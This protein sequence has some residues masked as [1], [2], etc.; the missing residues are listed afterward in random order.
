MIK[1]N[2]NYC[3][4]IVILLILISGSNYYPQNDHR[5]NNLKIDT[6]V[7]GISTHIFTQ[8]NLEDAKAA[9]SLML[10]EIIHNYWKRPDIFT[11]PA[12]YDNIDKIKSDIEANK[13]EMVALTSSEYFIL[14]DQVKIT[15][16]LT[17]KWGAI[18]QDRLLLL[19]REDSGIKTI[20]D[21][22]K[23]KVSIFSYVSDEFSL[24]TIWYKT[25]VLSNDENYKKDYGPFLEI[26]L[27][28]ARAIM[29]V[30]FKKTQAVIVSEKEFHIANELNP[31]LGKQLKIIANSKPILYSALCYTEKLK[32]HKNIFI[33]ELVDSFCNVHKKSIGKNFLQIFR[34]TQFIPYKDEYMNN[35]EELYNEFIEVSRKKKK[36]LE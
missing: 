30:F 8:A 36:Y 21:L 1:S 16:F 19:V 24:P 23:K 11:S 26:Q 29:D 2:K 13:L 6:V 33:Q 5:S 31:Q 14:K 4:K 25:L 20:K 18:T 32:Q 34:I 12:T 7:A 17:Y 35:T 27:K 15:P 3:F 9:L 28:S 22:K 10:N